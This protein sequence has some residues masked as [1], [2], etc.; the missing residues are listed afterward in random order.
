MFSRHPDFRAPDPSTEQKISD[1]LSRMTLEEKIDMLSGSRDQKADDGNSTPCRRLGI[2]SFRMADASAG[3]HWWTD[4]STTYPVLIALAASFDRDLAHRYGMAIGADCRAA[5]VHYL[6]GPGVN[7]YRSPLCG[8]NFE[9]LGEDPFLASRMVVAYVRGLQQMG[10]AATVKHFAVNYMEFDRHNVSSDVD[11]RTLREV[12]LLAFEAAVKEGGAAAIMTAYNL[13]NGVHCAEHE[14]LIGGILKGEWAFD[15]LVMSDWGSTYDAVHTAA[16]GID[17]EMPDGQWLNRENLVPA[18]RDG[19]LSEKVIDDKIRRLLRVAFAFG[20]MDRDQSQAPDPALGEKNAGLALEVARESIVLLKNDGILPLAKGAHARIAVIGTSSHPA[21]ISGG[22]SAW[23]KP[24]RSISILDGIKALVAQD[25]VEVVQVTGLEPWRAETMYKNSVFFTE[26]R[27][28]GVEVE[29]YTNNRLDGAPA[30]ARIEQRID[31]AWRAG[32][33]AEG[34]GRE[35]FS[36]RYRAAIKPVKAGR[37]YV[38]VH[39]WHGAYR[40]LVD[41]TTV[42]ES[43]ETEV[44]GHK[45]VVLDLDERSHSLVLEWRSVHQWNELRLGW[46]HEDAIRVDREKAIDAARHADLVVFCGGHTDKS[47]TEGEDRTFGMHEDVE[48]LLR[49]VLETNPNTVVVLT[50]GGNVDM[51]TWVDRARAIVHAWYPGQE[52]GT[53][54]AEILYGLVNPSGRLPAT[55]EHRLEDRSSFGCY[56]DSDGDKRVALTDGVFGGYRHHDRTGVAPRYAFGYGLSYTTFAYENLALSA[57]TLARGETLTVSFDVVNTGTVA[58]KEVAQVYVG[59]EAC[60]VPRPNKE[61]KGFEKVDLLPGERKR[62][63]IALDGRAF[64][65]WDI[66]A[67]A[68]AIEPGAFKIYL[69]ASAADIRVEGRID[70]A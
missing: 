36:I 38:H 51:R 55:F 6:L 12:Y 31:N 22:G 5:G 11:E 59:D 69:G 66:D 40:L 61:L 16:A 45:Q 41:G 19:R 3:V 44:R 20:W 34:I 25:G 29:Y 39:S 35:S 47:E 63:S 26:A 37:H 60:R 27:E 17:L 49:E 15:G 21:V 32:P 46:E 64:A 10:V 58:G 65:F 48:G 2:R 54:V 33:I 70:V 62:V 56:H 57:A 9:Y 52:G 23:S 28:P 42:I 4:S 68:W 18:V 14:H 67:N 13:V 43:W 50:G 1:L 8:R 7:I 24:W 53:A 30:L